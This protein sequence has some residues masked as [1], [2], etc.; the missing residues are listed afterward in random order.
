MKFDE[1]V[2]DLRSVK[3]KNSKLRDWSRIW[4][5]FMRKYKC[6]RVCELGVFKGGNFLEMIRHSP[7]LAVAVD[8]WNNDGAHSERDA[9]YTKEE[10]KAQYEYFK[11]QMNFLPFV[12]ILR[13]NS[14]TASKHFINNFFD[15]VYIDADH[16]FET[17]Y[18]DIINWYPK[19]KKGKFLVGHDYPRYGVGEAVNQFVKKEKLAL[20]T[21]FPSVWA[22]VK[23]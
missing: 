11:T 3:S 20:I 23:K 12:Q 1:V 5:P 10:L 7:K 21:L 8:T 15:F 19:V 6:D 13:E 17:T 18:S 22:V 14:S 16:S 9:K 2:K 4:E